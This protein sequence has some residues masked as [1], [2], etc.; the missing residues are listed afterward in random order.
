MA[1][2]ILVLLASQICDKSV[3]NRCWRYFNLVEKSCSGYAHYCH[4]TVLAV[5]KFGGQIK[6][7]QITK[8]KSPPNKRHIQYVECP[9]KIP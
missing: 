3:S 1:W 7:R 6:K 4:K 8:L 5:F 2:A 9:S